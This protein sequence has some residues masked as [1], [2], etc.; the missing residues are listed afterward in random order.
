MPAAPNLG[1][2]GRP[3]LRATNAAAINSPGTAD[4]AGVSAGSSSIDVLSQDDTGPV[5]PFAACKLRG[6][7]Y[8]S[9]S[10]GDI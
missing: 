9:N 2:G 7:S 10:G 8:C 5:N 4:G 6:K 1:G 3:I